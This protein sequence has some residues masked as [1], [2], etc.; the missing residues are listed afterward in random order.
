MSESAKRR[1]NPVLVGYASGTQ[2][3]EATP[4]R[5]YAP[6]D[7][8]GFICQPT[9]RPEPSDNIQGWGTPFEEC[10]EED[11]PNCVQINPPLGTP[12]V[13]HLESTN[14]VRLRRTV[15]GGIP[16][17]DRGLKLG[18]D[19]TV[20]I[21]D[22]EVQPGPNGEIPFGC[23]DWI[24]HVPTRDYLY[25]KGP[26]ARYGFGVQTWSHRE[27]FP[28]DE[29]NLYTN[30]SYIDP[31][32][33]QKVYWGAKIPV[34]CTVRHDAGGSYYKNTQGFNLVIDD[35]YNGTSYTGEP[36]WMPYWEPLY[37]NKLWYLGKV[38]TEAPTNS[39]T[40]LTGI[41]LDTL[42]GMEEH[43]LGACI[44][45]INPPQQHYIN[46]GQESLYAEMVATGA[47][48]PWITVITGETWYEIY[49]TQRL[50]YTYNRLRV[51]TKPLKYALVEQN[52][53]IYVQDLFD[54]ATYQL[55]VEEFFTAGTIEARADALAAIGTE[56]GKWHTLLETPINDGSVVDPED[57]GVIYGIIPNTWNPMHFN[58]SGTEA[59]GLVYNISQQNQHS[60]FQ[61]VSDQISEENKPIYE[62]WETHP[63]ITQ[64]AKVRIDP[65]SIIYGGAS[66]QWDFE[67]GKGYVE[68]FTADL[69]SH[70]SNSIASGSYIENT[71]LKGEDLFAVDFK[72]DEYV[73]AI[74]KIDLQSSAMVTHYANLKNLG[75]YKYSRS[76]SWSGSSTFIL[77]WKP[78][79][80]IP[81]PLSQRS[82]D[83]QLE[84]YDGERYWSNATGTKEQNKEVR[85]FMEMMDLR[86]DLFCYTIGDNDVTQTITGI[87]GTV[88][89]LQ[90]MII[91]YSVNTQVKEYVEA[92]NYDN[93]NV[94]PLSVSD[95][96]EDAL[97][98]IDTQWAGGGLILT[99]DDEYYWSGYTETL[100][101]SLS[102]DPNRVK[103]CV[104]PTNEVLLCREIGRRISYLEGDPALAYYDSNGEGLDYDF[105]T[106][107]RKF[108]SYYSVSENMKDSEGNDI[109]ESVQ[110]FLGLEAYP[111]N[112][113]CLLNIDYA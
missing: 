37:G 14:K 18:P 95:S 87:G 22:G 77:P 67:K 15:A 6:V 56:W 54:D 106:G 75:Y 83:Y 88:P 17:I 52:N 55:A 43:I 97:F 35:G 44:R 63:P 19:D 90:T 47:K 10:D 39:F 2:G 74:H 30:E 107:S 31:D 111:E 71:T 94:I 26:K 58:A 69:N 3:P 40:G 66:V 23:I 113:V 86:R 109:G 73:K 85:F 12:Q 60:G 25:Y 104:G 29:A 89:N 100:W 68:N 24:G 50:S 78:T 11:P 42:G 13:E 49:D 28:G 53:E 36:A 48:E 82:W 41:Q 96:I 1:Q 98:P 101:D 8:R 57:A 59:V 64:V 27:F 103:V 20:V 4:V 72:G 76:G 80:P 5:Y 51:H 9:V 34:R 7:L 81:G 65:D 84:S 102:F 108:M 32:T 92:P 105:Q 91:D 99:A 79:K 46:T 45:W 93:L 21:I 61:D 110:Q 33:S 70:V 62:N 38:L 16:K 112:L